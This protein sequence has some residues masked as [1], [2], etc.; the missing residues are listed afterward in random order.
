MYLLD[1]NIIIGILKLKQ[2]F[3]K[4]YKLI[5]LKSQPIYLTTYSL[6]EIYL[7]FHDPEFK[8]NFPKKLKI[9]I[10]LFN[11]MVKNLEAQKRIISLGVEDAKILGKLLYSLKAKGNPI[12]FIDA[13]LGAISISRK[14]TLIT[15]DQAHFKALKTIENTLKVEFW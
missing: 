8:Q 6:S 13:L 3:V 1:T 4:K 11:K 5:S 10:N 12:P 2:E 9:Q 15:T 14:M 7:G